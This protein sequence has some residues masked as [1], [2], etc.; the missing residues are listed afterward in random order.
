M[1][2]FDSPHPDLVF[3]RPSGGRPDDRVRFSV[4]FN[5]LKGH[6]TR[7]GSVAPIYATSFDIGAKPTQLCQ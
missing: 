6:R 4:N 7:V 3:N 1:T 2:E 5:K